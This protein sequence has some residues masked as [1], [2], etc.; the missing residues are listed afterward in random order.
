VH[1]GQAA[2]T[3]ED[4][5]K[6]GGTKPRLGVTGWLRKPWQPAVRRLFASDDEK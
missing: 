1:D 5:F 4:A 2:R 3:S 6:G